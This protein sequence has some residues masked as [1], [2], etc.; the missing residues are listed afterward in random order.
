M[1]G[2]YW[3]QFC[4]T[5]ESFDSCMDVFCYLFFYLFFVCLLMDLRSIKIYLYKKYVNIFMILELRSGCSRNPK[6]II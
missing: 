5:N 1:P 2:C 4:K 3:D 6:Y